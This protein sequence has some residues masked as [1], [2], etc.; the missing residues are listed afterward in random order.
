MAPDAQ[1]IG[2]IRIGEDTS[3]WFGTLVRGDNDWI[4]IGAGTNIQDHAVL[5]ADPGCPV[6]V[7]AD[8]TVGHSVILH[9][10]TIGDG[11]LIG[12]GATILNRAVIGRGCLV[13]AGALI[14]EGKTFPDYSLIMGSPAKV[15]RTLDEANVRALLLP[16]ARYIERS[17]L[18]ARTLTR[19]PDPTPVA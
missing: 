3:F 4:T 7:G 16:A 5:H 19:L 18:Y 8:C 11:S 17:A 2:Q 12:M 13:G 9:G 14:T 6:L 15:V 10:C 1:L